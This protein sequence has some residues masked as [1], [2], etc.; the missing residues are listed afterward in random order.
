MSQ[1]NTLKGFILSFCLKSPEKQSKRISLLLYFIIEYMRK[2]YWHE[3]MLKI[4]H[5]K[6]YEINLSLTEAVRIIHYWL[7]VL[8]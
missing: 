8:V 5:R 2:L 6:K 1:L 7:R 4:L 3:E